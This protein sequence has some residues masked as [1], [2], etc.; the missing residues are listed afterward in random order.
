MFCIVSDGRAELDVDSLNPEPF[1]FS[2]NSYHRLAMEE[3]RGNC[4][5]GI[6][7]NGLFSTFHGL[8]TSYET[9][10]RE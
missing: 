4:D 5:H 7:M 3:I 9:L 6:G 10:R 1:S 8:R 2:I